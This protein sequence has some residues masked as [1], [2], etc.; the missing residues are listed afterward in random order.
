[1]GGG[2]ND[3]VGDSTSSLDYAL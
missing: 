1:E 3:N 2:E